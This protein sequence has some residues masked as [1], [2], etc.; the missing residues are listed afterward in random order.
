MELQQ[1]AKTIHE[2]SK[3]GKAGLPEDLV[4]EKHLK[5]RPYQSTLDQL[6]ALAQM[7]K[8]PKAV[9]AMYLIEHGVDGLI[10]EINKVKCRA[11]S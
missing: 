2:R 3:V 1:Y 5:V 6:D 7:T 4:R 9:I 8:V 11:V 10:D